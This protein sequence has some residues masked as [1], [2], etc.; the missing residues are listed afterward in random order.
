M[1]N[2]PFDDLTVTGGFW[3]ELQE[4]VRRVTERAVYD[5]FAETGRIATMDCKPHPEF[6]KDLHVFW[7]SD[8]FKWMEGAAYLY[9]QQPDEELR[10]RVEAI[11]DAIEAG[12]REDGYYNSYF[13]VHEEKPRF[14]DRGAHE[15]YSLGHMIEAAVAW[16]RATG[17]ERFLTLCRRNV[18]LVD[19]IFRI[20]GSAGFETPGHEE[21][22]LAL[23]RL[24]DLTGEERY[25]AL[26]AFF[27]DRRGANDKDALILKDLGHAYE[28]SDLPARDLREAKGHAVRAAYYYCALVDLAER[29]PDKA[30]LTAAQR[31]FDD[32]YEHKMYIT[33]GIG[34][35]T[36]GEAFSAPYHLPNRD[37]YTETCAA[38]SLVLFCS[39]LY[40]AVPDGRYGDAA[41]RA[42]FNGMISGL[43]L[44]GDRFFYEN[45]LEIDPS[46]D[47]VPGLHHAP[48]ERVRVFE[49]SCCPPNLVRMTPSVAGLVYTEQDGTLF[50][51]QY[52]PTAGKSGG[53][54][55]R[56]ET[57]YPLSG[58]VRVTAG[59][60]SRLALR[61]PAWCETLTAD[62]PYTEKDGYLYFDSTEVA[63]EFAMTVRYMAANLC[64]KDDVDCVALM[65]GPIVYALEEQDQ[66]AKLSRIRIDPTVTPHENGEVFGSLPVLVGEGIALPSVAGLYAPYAP[67]SGERV[68]LRF[69]PYYTF[70]DRGEDAMR[71][72]NMVKKTDRRV[73]DEDR[74]T[75]ISG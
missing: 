42:L 57:D 33:G 51:H 36:Q 2:I 5:R 41:E 65:R 64:V 37:A 9:E 14:A 23:V 73:N 58:R 10:G 8:V 55:V 54:T 60:V 30:L 32:I 39:R 66:P 4:R 13:N 31:L 49:C 62:R 1:R 20:E 46:L 71:V 48:H 17:D 25:K 59:G 47:G 11:I 12:M 34:A 22:E 18:D 16:T 7:G 28:Q 50:V 56:M 43:S 68:P 21:I 75:G 29:L 27:V 61:R 69:I 15:L 35:V 26:A 38:L 19:R 45:P 44:S 72:W 67:V 53:V 74:S 70:A 63:V 24:Y 40:A 3:A 6:E 52:I